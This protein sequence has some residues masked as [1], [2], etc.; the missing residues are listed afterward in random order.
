LKVQ[1]DAGQEWKQVLPF[2][3]YDVSGHLDT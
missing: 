3:F 1:Y 2:G